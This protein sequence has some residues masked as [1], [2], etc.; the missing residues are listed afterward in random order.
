MSLEHSPA[1]QRISA[2]PRL[3]YTI[4]EWCRITQQSRATIYRQ[5]ADGRLRYVV[6]GERIRRIPAS[7]GERLGLV[8][9]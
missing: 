3:A 1:R 5:M 8:T 6:L 4:D 7:E 9:T 2:L